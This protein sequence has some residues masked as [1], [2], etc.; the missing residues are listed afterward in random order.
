M[1]LRVP[2]RPGLFALVEIF[3]KKMMQM[4]V[5]VTCVNEKDFTT[6]RSDQ[7]LQK[8]LRKSLE[9]CFECHYNFDRNGVATAGETKKRPDMSPDDAI[10]SIFNKW[11][12]KVREEELK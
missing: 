3:Q 7:G 12:I 11:R 6:V 8:L 4:G 9:Y 1:E 10:V 2:Q 5:H